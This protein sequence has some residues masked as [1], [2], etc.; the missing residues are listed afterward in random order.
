MISFDATR[1]AASLGEGIG[2]GLELGLV[3]VLV[4]AVDGENDESFRFE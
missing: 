4:A 1:S 2:L 3:V